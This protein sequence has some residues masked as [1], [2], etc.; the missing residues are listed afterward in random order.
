MGGPLSKTATLPSY[1]L[2]LGLSPS[3]PSLPL[4]Q[5]TF[6]DFLGRNQPLWPPFHPRPA[7]MG[8]LNS[9]HHSYQVRGGLSPVRVN[10]Y[11]EIL[12]GMQN[13]TGTLSH[14]P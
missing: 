4:L 12:P 2:C 7:P 9:P 14:W 11:K 8:M 6:V 5:V 10:S 13:D 1:R 3:Q